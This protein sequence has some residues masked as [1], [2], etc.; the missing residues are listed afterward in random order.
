[1]EDSANL[2][3]PDVLATEIIDELKAALDE[4]EQL[5]AGLEPAKAEERPPG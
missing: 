1:L 5:R 4:F 2:P 3:D